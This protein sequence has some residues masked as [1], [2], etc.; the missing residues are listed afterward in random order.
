MASRTSPNVI[1][2]IIAATRDEKIRSQLL[3]AQGYEGFHALLCAV[4]YNPD[5]IRTLLQAAPDDDTLTKMLTMVN[6]NNQNPLNRSIDSCPEY[7]E[8]LIDVCPNNA[9]L[10]QVLT[11]Q[12]DEGQ[13]ALHKAISNRHPEII[14]LI[15]KSSPDSSTTYTLLT[16]QDKNGNTPLILAIWY[17]YPEQVNALLSACSEHPENPNTTTATKTSIQKDVEILAL[18]CQELV[19]TEN[20]DGNTAF[21]IA[22]MMA[23]Q[24]G[25]TPAFIHTLLQTCESQWSKTRLLT[26]TNNKGENVLTHA[27]LSGPPELVELLI[28]ELDALP[29]KSL[30][31]EAAQQLSTENRNAIMNAAQH[32]PEVMVRLLNTCQGNPANIRRMLSAR[33]NNNGGWSTLEHAVGFHNTP[34]VFELLDI[35]YKQGILSE[36]DEN[37]R[38][39]RRALEYCNA[40]VLMYLKEKKYDLQPARKMFAQMTDDNQRER[41]DCRHI[42]IPSEDEKHLTTGVFSHNTEVAEQALKAG[43]TPNQKNSEGETP[44]HLAVVK[45]HS[46]ELVKVLLSNRADLNSVTRGYTPLQAASMFSTKC[47]APLLAMGLNTGAIRGERTFTMENSIQIPRFYHDEANGELVCSLCHDT[48]PVNKIPILLP[49]FHQM[50]CPECLTEAE[51][52]QYEDWY[53]YNSFQPF[54]CYLC[55]ESTRHFVDFTTGRIEYI[56]KLRRQ[57]KVGAGW[58]QYYGAEPDHKSLPDCSTLFSDARYSK[59]R[60]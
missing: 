45:H 60:L 49:C 58:H 5:Y 31:H 32:T 37:E 7:I 36:K 22:I 3:T 16:A 20:R 19:L 30:S 51:N 43:A 28:Q 52:H 14:P 2:T 44:L 57:V 15:L 6:I 27:S 21:S 54:Q 1:P 59:S 9:V 46:P 17:G 23:G 48:F 38:V 4:E 8:S 40:S 35:A 24:Y 34:H 13:N 41:E 39:Q 29:G 10:S 42:L 50:F 47:I 18:R 33:E 26:T 53:C 12:N 11:A 25:Y 55:K 56:S